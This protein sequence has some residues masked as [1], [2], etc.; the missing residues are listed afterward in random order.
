M[1]G[2]A[3]GNGLASR[4]GWRIGRLMGVYAV[5]ELTIGLSGI[6]LTVI[7]PLM[8]GVLAP[9]FRPFV[10][11]PWIINPLRLATSFC[12]M[13]VPTTAMGATLPLLVKA[14]G[15]WQKSFGAALGRFRLYGWNTLGAVVGVLAVEVFIVEWFGIRGAVLLAALLNVA[16]GLTAL[17]LSRRSGEQ[18]WWAKGSVKR[19]TSPRLS[20]VGRRLLAAAS[21]SG[22]ALLILEVVWFR[23]LAMFV[24]TGSLAFCMMLAVVLLGV[25]TGGLVASKILERHEGASRFLPHIASAS[26]ICC[27]ATYAGFQFGSETYSRAE[28]WI[29]ILE[30]SLRLVLPVSLLSGLLFTFQGA[31]LREEVPDETRAAGLLTLANTLGATAGSFLAGFVLLP[32]LGMEASFFLVAVVY[33]LISMLLIKKNILFGEQKEP[34]RL[35]GAVVVL[36]IAIIAFPFGL[37]EKTYFPMSAKMFQADGSKTQRGRAGQQGDVRKAVAGSRDADRARGD[38]LRAAGTARGAVHGRQ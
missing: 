25:G 3:L 9:V 24:V 17:W 14:L 32:F 5:A 22:G 30:F 38:R 1:C 11:S 37:M 35:V 28:D 21:L 23:F 15:R 13:L 36:G 6:A 20:P 31:A 2:L 4:F 12:L 26:A 34:R 33:V 8:T 18:G 10:D 27:V 29:S 19:V 16:A 7:L